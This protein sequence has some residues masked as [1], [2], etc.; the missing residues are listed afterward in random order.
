M[1]TRKQLKPLELV[2]G[3]MK[4]SRELDARLSDLSKEIDAHNQRIAKKQELNAR[5]QDISESIADAECS[6]GGLRTRFYDATFNQDHEALEDIQE[7]HAS[8]NAD[9]ENYRLEQAEVQNQLDDIV[10]DGVA[11]A[12]LA[13]T[14]KADVKIPYHADL[15]KT[16]EEEFRSLRNEQDRTLK[17]LRSSVP[18][19]LA[20]KQTYDAAMKKLDRSYRTSDE[21]K[22]AAERFQAQRAEELRRIQNPRAKSSA[23]IKAAKERNFARANSA[24]QP[25]LHQW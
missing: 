11:I 9:I 16:L 2:D 14:L 10:I 7:R 4:R 3:Y 18:A 24:P 8:L 1:A 22:K 17:E 12:E 5:L 23:E 20:D 6:I 25:E 19:R 21:V 15:I 13:A